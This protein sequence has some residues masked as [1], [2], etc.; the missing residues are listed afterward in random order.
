VYP[1]G[2]QP[3][4]DLAERTLFLEV[5]PRLVEG[6]A[7]EALEEM[8]GLGVA[9]GTIIQSVQGQ[10]VREITERLVRQDHSQVKIHMVVVVVVAQGRLVPLQHQYRLLRLVPVE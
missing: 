7:A 3:D 6:T 4:L 8:V 10:L 1:L 5:S 9:P 2:A